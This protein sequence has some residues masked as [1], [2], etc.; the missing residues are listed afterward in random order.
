MAG[1]E[2]DPEGAG[3]PEVVRA[4]SGLT[5]GDPTRS[6]GIRL[7]SGDHVF[8]PGLTP[9]EAAGAV[10]EMAGG[11]GE[12]LE[13]AR[14]ESLLVRIDLAAILS[15]GAGPH[16]LDA[17]GRLTIAVGPHPI[18]SG[19][20]LAMGEPHPEHT[21]GVVR[22]LRDPDEHPLMWRWIGRREVPPAGRAAALDE[23]DELESVEAVVAWAGD[24]PDSTR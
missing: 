23:L 4:A 16:L 6:R 20:R 21:I 3:P 5:A 12:S 11:V 14:L 22:P 2:V 15:D 17:A 8:F 19:A 18:I 13:D 7:A 9:G 10:A 24:A 1:A